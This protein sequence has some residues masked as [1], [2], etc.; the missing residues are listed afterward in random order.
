MLVGA[1]P[2]D[3][4]FVLPQ[5]TITK[6]L[7]SFHFLIHDHFKFVA[8]SFVLFFCVC[9]HNCM[10]VLQLIRLTKNNWS[11]STTIPIGTQHFLSNCIPFMWPHHHTRI[12]ECSQ[13]NFG[14]FALFVCLNGRLALLNCTLII[15][16]FPLWS[17][18][19][20]YSGQTP[21]PHYTANISVVSITI[22]YSVSF[23]I[24]IL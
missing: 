11:Q 23:I 5:Y 8:W 10:Y 18:Q 4:L 17:R 21:S 3:I 16:E 6:G 12:S 24:V 14:C 19:R 1:D 2:F 7:L 13:H 15:H 9:I 22:F 20:L